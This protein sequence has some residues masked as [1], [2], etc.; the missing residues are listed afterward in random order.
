[1]SAE[2]A[3]EAVDH[4]SKLRDL[5]QRAEA[6]EKLSKAELMDEI[7]QLVNDIEN[8]PD[9]PSAKRIAVGLLLTAIGAA[10]VGGVVGWLIC[11]KRLKKQYEE[12]VALE[13]E[14]AREHYKARYKTDE[15][16]TPQSAAQSLG[17]NDDV[18]LAKAARAL[19]DYQGASEED[20]NDESDDEPEPVE[21]TIEADT[22]NVFETASKHSELSQEE[23]D[24]RTPTI[25]YIIDYEEYMSADPGYPQNHL[26]YY[27][28]DDILA[29][30]KDD[31]IPDLERVVGREN[32]VFGK[33]SGDLDTVFIRNDRMKLDFE[34]TRSD[35]LYSQEVA[36]F[37]HSDQTGSRQRDRHER[38]NQTRRFRGDDE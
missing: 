18:A 17:A 31:P 23:R 37:Q 25:P 35:G 30:D 13:V 16:A 27:E 32:L 9:I 29:D 7:K 28:G 33:A 36:G 6:L 4:I 10:G 22:V 38:R 19:V 2:E 5:A 12:Q 3:V 14:E 20:E 11:Q 26:T 8:L 15:Y 24:N 1:M 34:I 21:V